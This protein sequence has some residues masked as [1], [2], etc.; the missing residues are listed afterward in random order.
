[1]NLPPDLLSDLDAMAASAGRASG[2]LKGLANPQ[3]LLV[4]CCLVFLQSN[5]LAWML[6][7]A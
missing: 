3:R 2:F 4:L 6:P 5:V 7:A 1:M